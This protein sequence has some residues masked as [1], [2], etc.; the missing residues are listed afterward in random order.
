MLQL[1]PIAI[2]EFIEN[3]NKDISASVILLSSV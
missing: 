1:L 3:K 2:K